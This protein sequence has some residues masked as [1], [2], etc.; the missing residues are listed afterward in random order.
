MIMVPNNMLGSTGHSKHMPWGL[1]LSAVV[2]CICRI[3]PEAEHD[4][5]VHFSVHNCLA[6]PSAMCN[7]SGEMSL[8]LSTKTLVAANEHC[9]Q[10]KLKLHFLYSIMNSSSC[11][12]AA[13]FSVQNTPNLSFCLA[14]RTVSLS[15]S[16][17]QVSDVVGHGLERCQA[18][19]FNTTSSPM[20]Q[21]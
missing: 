1:M 13:T 4:A 8:D 11:G 20:E 19:H 6:A 3:P 17:Q 12:R 14:Y 21:F 10:F 15:V 2:Q 5:E 16:G 18:P 7:L 9:W